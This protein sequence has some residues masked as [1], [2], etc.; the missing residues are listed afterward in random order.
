[1]SFRYHA[2]S[3]INDESLRDDVNPHTTFMIQDSD[4][5]GLSS[6]SSDY[7]EPGL[8]SKAYQATSGSN[9]S[10]GPQVQVQILVEKYSRPIS[11]IA[12]FDTGV[13]STMMN[14][15]VLPPNAWKKKDNEFLTADGQIFTTNLVSKQK[16]DIQFFPTCT[17]W[18]HV[19][20]TPI[21]DKDILI[22]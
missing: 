13:H 18:T 6:E 9:L 3:G 8:P 17:L 20:G 11:A 15:R 22:G 19:I 10:L 16:T 14:P 21:L 7:S 4:D 5:S 1:M 12:Y 2:L